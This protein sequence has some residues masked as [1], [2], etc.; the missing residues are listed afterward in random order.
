MGDTF[1][2]LF[3]MSEPEILPLNEQA[4]RG[5]LRAPERSQ[6]T[7]LLR[8]FLERFFNHE[9]ASP[10]GD[11]KSRMVLFACAAGLPPF[12]VAM[13]LWPVYH[14][15]I[16]WPPGNKPAGPP[17]Y[18]LQVNHHFFFVV[19]AFVSMGIA[20]VFEWDLF[21]PDLLDI[22]V[23][24][25][26][27]I[28]ESRIF[29]ARVAAIAIF[30]AG[31][32]FD[33]NFLPPFVLPAATD[34]PNLMRFLAGHVLAVFGSAI[35]A[36]VFILA[37]QSVALAVCGERLFRKFSL[38]AQGFAIAALLVLLLLF[39]VF[40]GVVPAL[41]Q[42]GSR[43][44]FCIPPFWFLGIYQRL[45][46]GPSA[47]PV[48]SHLAQ[49]GCAATLGSALLAVLAYPFAYVRRVRQLVVGP[50]AHSTRSRMALPLNRLLH[51]TFVRPAV[52]R[53]VYHFIGQTI[54]RV[55]RYRIYL[56]LYG[57][58]GVSVFVATILRFTTVHNQ[59]H[60]AISADG[61]R[62]A[63]GVVAFWTIAGLRMAFVSSGNQRGSW[64]FHVVH[65]KPAHFPPA[66]EQL[67]AAKVWVLV[68]AGAVLA[69]TCAF[70][71]AIAPPEL[72]TWPAAAS[73]WLVA[74]GMCLLLTD[75]L[76][77]SVTEIA[78]TGEPP[79]TPPN[80]A[81]TVLKYFLF[82]PIVPAFPVAVEPWIE[83]NAWH[84]AIAGTGFVLAHLALRWRH[85]R[86]AREHSEQLALED[87]EEDFPM[88][89][90]LRY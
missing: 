77:L 54:L 6:F 66:I 46:E 69:A 81:F 49:L 29:R 34:P 73:Q 5:V 87:D 83:K 8:H 26:L 45:L 25:T 56:V 31:F 12:V 38:A 82:F 40:S 53:A 76:F 11:A 48:Y 68:W 9:T 28:L 58:V 10:D 71:H 32:L 89:L 59:V 14:P 65:G 52:R 88:K 36:A 30:V 7:H 51:L 20:T 27:P 19:Y 3:M 64:I 35:F 70:L 24:G 47:L 86:I 79:R 72:R 37:L 33:A 15:F 62:A 50:G 57:G 21:F 13:Y 78:F 39:P 2:R 75:I 74:A 90:G 67:L 23:L 61:V 41:L 60:M 43:I 63:V 85:R 17:S 1:Q 84:F 80:L 4:A 16:G 44:P 55:P 42:S 22:F 18:W